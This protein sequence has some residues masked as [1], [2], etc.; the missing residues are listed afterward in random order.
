MRQKS[1]GDTVGVTSPLSAL[2]RGNTRSHIAPAAPGRRCG[3]PLP[4]PPPLS[5]APLTCLWRYAISPPPCGPARPPPWRPSRPPR[6]ALASG[7]LG[8]GDGCDGGDGSDN[9]NDGRGGGWGGACGP[10]RAT[11]AAG[12]CRRPARLSA[13]PGIHPAVDGG[14]GGS[15][16]GW[17]W[18]G[19][20]GRGRCGGR[21][22]GSHRRRVAAAA[23]CGHHCAR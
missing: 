17:R 5:R 8:G 14:G 19:C 23:E 1:K 15:G 21:G 10:P 13:I 12:G 4:P 2:V 11:A 18:R 22:G 3:R 16:G 20:R 6:R 7:R 9:A